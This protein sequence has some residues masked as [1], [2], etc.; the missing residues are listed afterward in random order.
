MKNTLLTLMIALTFSAM[1]DES[2]TNNS[3][4]LTMESDSVSNFI[5]ELQVAIYQHPTFLAAEAS[6]AQ[7]SQLVNI[8][9]SNRRPQLS[10][11]TST[12]NRFSSSFDDKFSFFE[13]SPIKEQTNASLVIRQLLFDSF[14]TSH[15]IKQQKNTLLA[16]QLVQEQQVFALALKMI[17]NCL[18]TASYYLLKE[19]ITDSVQRHTEITEQIK[20]RVDSGRAPMREL[21]RANARLAEAQAKQLNTELSYESVLAEFRQLMPNTM[22]CKK[23]IAL[24]TKDLVLDS[25]T[26]VDNAL[27]YNLSIQESNMRIKAAEENLMRI[28]ANRWPKVSLKVQG[29]KY[30][31]EEFLTRQL[32]D[33]DFYA[34]IN[35]D[36]DLYSGGRKRSE[37]K[38]A[39]EQ[40][41]EVRFKKDELV[42]NIT[43]STESLLSEL[44]NGD[45]RV[46]I[47]K[48]AFIAN[49]M[50]RDNLRLQFVSS[51]VSLLE[52]LQAERD[53][54]ESSENMV[55]NQRSVLL[56]GFTELALL[57]KLMNYINKNS[58][59]SSGN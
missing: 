42:K 47:F 59:G 39:K 37:I 33:Y 11:Q 43:A 53:Y 38:G 54:L 44:K 24:S 22:A 16:D 23:M 7:S 18:D 46:E 4:S 12:T 30:N 2:N 41:N 26:A 3:V 52:L 27:A 20:V 9:K 8:A 57:G 34:G 19:M 58:K 28:K 14:A 55:F 15:Q 50:S 32:D 36:M 5:A 29:D 40:L 45:K 25:R 17:T 6:V 48:Q 51:N 56:A 13:S 1:A 21:T 31:S 10:L 35:F 49:D